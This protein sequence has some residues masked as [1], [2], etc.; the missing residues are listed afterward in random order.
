MAL[1]GRQNSALCACVDS[2]LSVSV[3]FDTVDNV[4][5]DYGVVCSERA[6]E[7]NV[8]RSSKLVG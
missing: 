8:S 1:R 3:Y 6:A 4:R 7:N 5:R 2:L